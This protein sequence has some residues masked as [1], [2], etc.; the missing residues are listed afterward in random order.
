MLCAVGII[1]NKIL[2]IAYSDLFQS[3]LYRQLPAEPYLHRGIILSVY[4]CTV[5]VKVLVRVS[6]VIYMAHFGGH[7]LGSVAHV[8]VNKSE[9]IAAVSYIH[10]SGTSCRSRLVGI[11]ILNT[12]GVAVRDAKD[13]F[14]V[15]VITKD[16]QYRCIA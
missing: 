15:P 12:Y 14:I 11:V 13:W 5:I 6:S 2:R 9:L 1:I 4:I 10:C 7:G 8:R 3:L 16:S